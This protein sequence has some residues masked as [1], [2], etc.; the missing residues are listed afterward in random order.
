MTGKPIIVLL[1][2]YHRN[3]QDMQQL[4]GYFKDLDYHVFCPDMPTNSQRLQACVQ[5]ALDFLQNNELLTSK[6]HLVGHSYGGLIARALLSKLPE[7]SVESLTCIG[8]SHQGTLL[9]DV[10]RTFGAHKKEPAIL[11]FCRPGPQIHT[12]SKAW[13]PKVHLIAGSHNG[14][15]WGKF[16][17]PKLSDGRL[18]VQSA[19]DLHNPHSTFPSHTKR[20]TLP[21]DHHQLMLQAQVANCVH[22]HITSQ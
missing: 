15:W 1:H 14:L 22:N 12:D 9:A 8:S 20:S 2:G 4:A 21:L 17:L 13:P 19:L 10:L 18:P 16:L 3:A 7:S 11:E 5:V 6:L